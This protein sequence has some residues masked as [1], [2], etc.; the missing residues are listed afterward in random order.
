MALPLLL[1]LLLLWPTPRVPTPRVAAGMRSP[2]ARHRASCR[3][4][5]CCGKSLFHGEAVGPSHSLQFAGIL[6]RVK[7]AWPCAA[8]SKDY[9]LALPQ[10]DAILNRQLDALRSAGISS[11]R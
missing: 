1:L 3:G 5:H 4:V 9:G 11:P 7:Q 2:A 6:Q 8:A 10:A